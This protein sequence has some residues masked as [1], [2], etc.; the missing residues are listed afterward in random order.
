MNQFEMLMYHAYTQEGGVVGAADLNIPAPDPDTSAVGF[1]KAEED[2]HEGGLSRAVFPQKRVDFPL[3]HLEPDL[4]VGD[5]S[6]KYLGNIK[7]LNGGIGHPL[8][9]LPIPDLLMRRP[10]NH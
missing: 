1:V 7:H 6:G 5:N 10:E 2:G 3:L 4:V 9:L 8:L